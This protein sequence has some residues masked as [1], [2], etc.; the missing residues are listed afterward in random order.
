MINKFFYK[1]Y[2]E[3]VDRYSEALASDKPIDLKE[4][5]KCHL[6]KL[7]LTDHL[8]KLI[9]TDKSESDKRKISLTTL[10]DINV[11]VAVP[12][13][14]REIA[15]LT[16]KRPNNITSQFVFHLYSILSSNRLIDID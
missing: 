3:I 10:A 6:A 5:E 4:A 12:H 9:F 14:L 16:K 8:G 15:L 7:V 2:I 13:I 1:E 11:E